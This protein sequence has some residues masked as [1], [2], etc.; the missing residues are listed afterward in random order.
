MTTSG[1]TKSS[2]SEIHTFSVAIPTLTQPA[3]PHL[4]IGIDIIQYLDLTEE[5]NIYARLCLVSTLIHSGVDPVV[6]E[7]ST[8]ALDLPSI[9]DVKAIKTT[10]RFG[11]GKAVM[12]QLL[13]FRILDKMDP[14]TGDE[15][16]MVQVMLS[17]KDVA[18]RCA[19]CGRWEQ[20]S[21]DQARL[22]MCSGC[23]L[24]WFCDSE[25]QRENW[26]DG[27][28]TPHKKVCRRMKK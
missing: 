28:P 21:E 4:M 10:F 1:P 7:L 25:C 22:A 8:E 16:P 5:H 2:T 24:A 9:D 6:L 3:S 20:Q 15:H 18:K 14:V 26:K 11:A 17:E 23:K 19:Q 13:H 27:M 12:E